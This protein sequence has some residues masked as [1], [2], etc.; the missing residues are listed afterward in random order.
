MPV[1]CLAADE[2]FVNFHNAAEFGFRFDQ[3]GAIDAFR[4]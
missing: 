3:S 4:T 2:C 1:L